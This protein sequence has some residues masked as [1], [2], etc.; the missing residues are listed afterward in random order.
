MKMPSSTPSMSA[1]K[2]D[3]LNGLSQ[4]KLRPASVGTSVKA[5]FASATTANAASVAISAVSS[6]RCVLAL[7]SMPMTQI[8][9]MTAIHTTPTAVTA[10]V[11][12]AAD[13]QPN[14]RNV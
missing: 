3:T 14:S 11:V 9:V 4:L 7:S 8:Q 2:L 10:H 5:T 12:S 6:Q 13:C 1:L